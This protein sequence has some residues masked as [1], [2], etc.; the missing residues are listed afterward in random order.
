MK[1]L[2][3]RISDLEGTATRVDPRRDPLADISVEWLEAKIRANDALPLEQRLE[4]LRNRPAPP[5]LYE[6]D[7]QAFFFSYTTWGGLTLARSFWLN[8]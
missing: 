3:K 1:T 6:G 2:E 5:R 8:G 7:D 4:N